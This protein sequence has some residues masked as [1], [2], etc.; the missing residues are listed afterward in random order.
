MAEIQEIHEY[1]LTKDGDIKGIRAGTKN[2][3]IVKAPFIKYKNEVL[4]TKDNMYY[5]PKNKEKKFRCE[6]KEMKG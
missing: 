3:I 4:M 6:E 2:I 5:L 1:C